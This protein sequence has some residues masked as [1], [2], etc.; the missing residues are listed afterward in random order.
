[1]SRV[2]IRV[3]RSDGREMT[4]GEGDWRIPSDGLENWANLPY[5]VSASELSNRDG[6]IVVSKRVGSVDR[7]F[8]ARTADA[9]RSSELRA[10]AI[11]FFNPKHTFEAHLTYRGR[12][13]WCRGEQAGFKAGEGNVHRPAEITWTVLCPD[14]Y[15]LSEGDFGR[16][17]AEVVPMFGFP[18]MSFLPAEDGS[19][20]G[21]GEGF[22]ASVYAF[23][24]SAELPNGGDVPSGAR[25]EIA[26]T[27]D[28]LNPYVALGDGWVRYPGALQA[29]DRLSVDA[30]GIPPTATLNGASALHLLDRRSSVVDMRVPTGGAEVSYGADDGE[31]NMR[32]TVYYNERYLGI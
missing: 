27:G 6:A 14:P 32:V 10:R 3:V 9:S 25:V 22:A 29:G 28:V 21:F 13:R 4:F 11:E 15:L 1:M 7:T 2:S 17:I 20:E 26:A 24:A 19:A 16:N 5:S 12:T 30:G 23:G 31:A 8:T 18:F